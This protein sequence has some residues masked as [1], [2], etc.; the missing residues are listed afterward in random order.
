[1]KAILHKFASG[2]HY[3]IVD[4]DIAEYFI[5][6]GHKR[7]LCT[8]NESITFHC[9][10]MNKKEGGYFVNVGST[11]RNDLNL[12]AGDI[13]TATFSP[14]DSEFQFDTPQELIEILHNDIEAY[15]IFRCLSEGNQRGLI[16]LVN[17]VKSHNKRI[18]RSLTIT[19]KLKEGVTSPRKMLE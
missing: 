18:E 6:K 8:L 16:Y 17:Q 13:I 7:V 5:N 3:F 4:N 10:L 2:M 1:M 9:A 15:N 14:D 19:K 12:N 11:I